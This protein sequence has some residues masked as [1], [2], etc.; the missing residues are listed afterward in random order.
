[1][2][3]YDQTQPQVTPEQAR[4]KRQQAIDRAT[5]KALAQAEAGNLPTL[6]RSY[7]SAD[8][9]TTTQHWLVTSRTRGE[10]TYNVDLSADCDGLKTLCTCEAAQADRICWHRS[11]ARLAALG[12]IKRH[13]C[14]TYPPITL[15]ELHGRPDPWPA[16]DDVEAFAAVS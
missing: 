2:S 5:V 15:G 1:M 9:L 11:A 16:T 12:Q 13:E 4:R 8:G 10:T 7:T 6:M 14:P 3:T